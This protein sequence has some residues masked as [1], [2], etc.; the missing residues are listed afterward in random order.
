M[1]CAQLSFA[2]KNIFEAITQ[3]RS[4]NKRPDLKS[5]H[6][7][8]VRIEKVKELS[9]QYLQE[10]ILQLE[11]EGR[12]VNKKFKGADSFFITETKAITDPPQSPD[13]SFPIIQDTPLTTPSPDNI[14]NLQSELHELRR[15]V[16]A[17]KSVF[18][19]Q[20]LLIKENQK[21]VNEQPINDSENNSELINLYLT[22]LN[23]CRG[24]I[25]LKLI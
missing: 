17:T 20:F 24:K 22:R 11:D 14:S 4:S 10:L 9:K 7:Y 25:L 12:F 3:I 23:T 2:Q 1:A 18:L 6:S 13:P 19:E 21:L 5:I 8:L 15:E 16:V